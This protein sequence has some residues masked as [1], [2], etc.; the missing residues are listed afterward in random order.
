[1]ENPKSVGIWI[2]VS[3]DMQ[4]KDDSPEHHER[5]ARLYAESKGWNVLEVYRLEAVS[6]KAVIEHPEAKRMLKDIRDKKIDGLIFSKLAR[7]ARNTKEL[8]EFSEIFRHNNADLISLSENV[9]TSSPAGRLFYTIIAA[10]AE[11][12]RAEIADRVAASVPIRARMGKPLGGPA[13]FGYRWVD[14]QYVV[15]EKEAPVR[16]VL[17][18]VFLKHKR[19]KTT[20]DQLNTMGYRTRNGSKFTDTTVSRLL[21]DPSAKGERRANYTKSTGD[22]KHWELKP[23]S[24]WII[25]PCEPIVSSELWNECNRLLDEQEHKRTKPGRTPSHLLSGFV[26]CTCGKS[27][28]VFHKTKIFTC[29]NCKRRIPVSDLDEIFHDQLK[30]FL[31][32]DIELDQFLNQSGTVIN[33]KET[34]LNMQNEDISKV[35]K[36]MNELVNMRLNGEMNRDSFMQHHTPL[37]ERLTQL[38]ERLP[39]LQA[40]I[41]ILKIQYLSSDTVLRD[42][43]DLYQRWSVLSFEE[44][45]NIVEVITNKITVGAED[46]SINLSYLPHNQIEGNSQRNFKDSSRQST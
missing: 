26:F 32:T 43:K 5:R 39:N 7:L 38:Q 34:L 14:K 15:D 16:K 35:T 17:Y 20:A 25:T 6:G 18:E 21:R 9:D 27:M 24:D 29:R 2:R 4:V 45:R 33:E 13:P 44:K 41:D 31:L 3:T 12:E 23:T 37:E 40:E 42:A 36:K 11:W 22:K 8:L 19:K 10:M 28:Y 46:I 1:M 30:S